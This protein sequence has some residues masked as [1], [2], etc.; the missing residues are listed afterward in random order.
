VQFL[1]L[2]FGLCLLQ[3]FEGSPHVNILPALRQAAVFELRAN[4]KVLRVNLDD[5]KRRATGVTYVTPQGDTIDQPEKR[6]P[7][8]ALPHRQAI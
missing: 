8:H 3:L 7:L 2:L 1:R 4:S 6:A 5:T